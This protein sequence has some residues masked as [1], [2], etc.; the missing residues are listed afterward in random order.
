VR[1]F[2]MNGGER[3]SGAAVPAVWAG[4]LL[5][6][7]AV[8]LLQVP[9]PF[10]DLAENLTRAEDDTWAVTFN[11]AFRPGVEFRPLLLIWIKLGFELFGVNAWAYQLMVVLQYAAALALLIWLLRPVGVRRGIGAALAI[12][13]LVGLHSS[14][15]MF[16]VVPVNA[17][18]MGVI[19]LLLAA[20]LAINAP[21]PRYDWLFLPLTACALL[22]LESGIVLAPLLV[23]LRLMNAPGVSWRGATLAA[24]ATVGYVAVRQMGA[25]GLPL[26]YTETGFGLGT[27]SIQEL[28]TRFEDAVWMFWL[29]NSA[30]TLFTVLFSEPRGGTFVFVRSLLEGGAPTWMW[31][32]VLSSTLTTAA[33][34]VALKVARPTPRDKL[35]IAVG[36]VLLLGGSALG[37]MYTRDRIALTAGLGYVVL[38]FVAFSHF[39]DRVP[40]A[41]PGVRVALTAAVLSLAAL[42]T[43][44]AIETS[45]QLRDAAWDFH[46][47]WK[48]RFGDQP[49]GSPGS[50]A[51]QLRAATLTRPPAD[52]R[53]DPAWTFR[54]FERKF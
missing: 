35:L 15:A 46:M 21:T 19:V 7:L 36:V 24:A 45:F 3:D 11:R 48:A 17:P 26:V 4:L 30:A 8:P 51:E 47:E 10:T 18:S 37:F 6:A 27:P 16:I 40:A 31:L 33:I 25:G 22:L 23:V 34:V 42:W 39:L 41:A 1:S 29:Y 5:V 54:Y 53:A 32:H 50:V 14:R 43:G 28:A 2:G 44:R 13:C 12:T 9:L 20:V 52:P 38:V 49:A